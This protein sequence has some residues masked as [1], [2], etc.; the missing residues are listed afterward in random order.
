MVDKGK[1][2]T[3]KSYIK[4]KVNTTDGLLDG[5][6]M[7]RTAFFTTASNGDLVYPVNHHIN[8]QLFYF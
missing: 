4:S 5:R 2:Y 8:Y 1:G 7:G 3:Y 6:P